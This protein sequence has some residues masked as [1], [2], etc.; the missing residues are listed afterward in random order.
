M[1]RIAGG[2]ATWSSLTHWYS[3]DTGFPPNLMKALACRVNNL[4]YGEGASLRHF[5]C[6]K[7]PCTLEEYGFDM[8]CLRLAHKIPC[9]MEG[10][11]Q[12]HTCYL[13]STDP[14]LGTF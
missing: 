3:F 7:D 10:S 12:G 9:H 6:F 11:T 14:E 2:V 1:R 5:A 8:R 13:Y 4:V